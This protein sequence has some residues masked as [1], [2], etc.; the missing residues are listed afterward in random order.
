VSVSI[1]CSPAGLDLLRSRWEGLYSPEQHTIFQ[2]FAW[3]RLAAAV[4]GDREAPYVVYAENST[5]AALIPAAI[6]GHKISFLGETLFDYR[7]VLVAG[8]GQALKAAWRELARLRLPLSV[9]AVRGG[10]NRWSGFEL[11]PFS[12]APCV[13]RN[14]QRQLTAHSRAG[15]L[16][17]RLER[18]GAELKHHD[19][20]AAGLLRNIYHHKAEQSDNNLFTDLGRVEFVLKALALAPAA[21]DVFTFETAHAL[22]AALVTLRDG[23]FRRFYTT[24]FDQAWAQDSPGTA[25]LFEVTRQSLAEGLDCDYMTGT[26]PQKQRFATSSVPL[27]RVEASAEQLARIAGEAAPAEAAA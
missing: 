3:N 19:G 7:D 27:F 13:R 11:S 16:V 10:G 8:D 9:T 25:L 6:V 5:G 24:W 2:S 20:S 1:A 23:R 26:Q 12:Q 15:R 22:V 18:K 14:D 4:F 17:R 21:V